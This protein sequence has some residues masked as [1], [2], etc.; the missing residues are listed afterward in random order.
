M[1]KLIFV[2]NHGGDANLNLTSSGGFIDISFN[3]CLVHP[4]TLFEFPFINISNCRAAHWP[5]P[6]EV[7]D[8]LKGDE[9]SFGESWSRKSSIDKIEA[10]ERLGIK[11]GDAIKLS[12]VEFEDFGEDL[13]GALKGDVEDARREMKSDKDTLDKTDPLEPSY[14][15]QW[16]EGGEVDNP[17]SEFD[18]NYPD[19]NNIGES[20]TIRT[21]YE[22]E[23]CEK[24][25]AYKQSYYKHLKTCKEKKKDE[26]VKNSM[27]EL[28][29]L[30]NKQNDESIKEFKNTGF[31][32]NVLANNSSLKIIN[33]NNN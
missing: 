16:Q 9:D 18:Q 2:W 24:V 11:Q 10:L 21:K 22:C 27:N 7:K 33:Y 15:F 13:Q 28:V 23:F 25:L 30:L 31:I 12:G 19:Y 6:E 17:N 14:S 32:T 4:G 8:S 20:Q 3:L 29:V 26:E 5:I 1:T